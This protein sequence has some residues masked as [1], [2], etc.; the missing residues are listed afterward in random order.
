MAFLER[1]VA[2][3]RQSAGN[4]AAGQPNLSKNTRGPASSM[5]TPAASRPAGGLASPGLNWAPPGRPKSAAPV[6]TAPK[7]VAPAIPKTAPPPAPRPATPT[8]APPAPPATGAAGTIPS[9]P[10][11]PVLTSPTVPEQVPPASPQSLTG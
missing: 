10:K 6:S 5:G 11:P 1:A 7:P 8:A 2:A 4:P 3:A 9:Y